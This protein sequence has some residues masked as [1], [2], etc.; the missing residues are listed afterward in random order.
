[1]KANGNMDYYYFFFFYKLFKCEDNIDFQR[2][3][4]V[5]EA[6]SLWIKI[7]LTVSTLYCCVLL[8]QNGLV[9]EE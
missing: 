4:Y 2:N 3:I 8:S 1:M 9:G 5:S 7:L 6:F